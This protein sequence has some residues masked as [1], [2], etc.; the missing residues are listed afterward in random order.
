MQ[1]LKQFI[2]NLTNLILISYGGTP[3]V[4]P[5][6][7]CNLINQIIRFNNKKDE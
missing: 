2:I 7:Q 3:I 5:S 6:I 4:M 1:K